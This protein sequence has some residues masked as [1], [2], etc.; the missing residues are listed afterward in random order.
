MAVVAGFVEKIKYRNEN[1]GWSILSV[2]AEGEEYVLVGT[3][4]VISEGEFI[5]AEGVMKVHPVY[6]EQLVV[7]SYEIKEPEDSE[8]VKR[9]LSSGAVKGIG[10]TLAARIVKRFKA[11]TLH[12]LEE[13][14][15]RLAE[16]KGISERM[17]M[18]IGA[19]VEEKREMR[20]A[21][22]FLSKFGI[23]MNLGVRI[24][25]QYGDRIYT[26]IREN[27][28]QLADEMTG[29]GFRI[30]DE[31]A[32][33]AGIL[34]DSEYRI[35]CG[36]LYCLS[37]AASQGHTYL[38][39]SLL[40][41]RTAELLGIEPEG[42]RQVL[43]DLQ[44][45]RKVV[46]KRSDSGIPAAGSAPEPQEQEDYA[47][48]PASFYYMELNV[49]AMLHDLD[50]RSDEAEERILTV[51]RGMEETDGIE[52][53]ELQRQAVIEAARSGLLIITGGPGTGKT[54]TI[55]AII[56]YFERQGAEILLAAPTG[57]AAKRM[58]ETTGC[59]AKTI[60]R[61][62]EITGAPSDEKESGSD[63]SGMHFERNE[64]MP[65]EADCVIIDEMSMVD[66]RLMH[67]LLKAVSVGTHLVL[68]GDSNQLPSVGPGNVLRDMISCNCFNV[69]RLDRIYRQAAES[70]IVVNAHRMIDG[71][72]IDL[73]K[74]SRDF[75]FIRQDQPEGI[76]NTM[77]TLIRDKLPS[78][79]GAPA[80]ELQ[81]MTPM[82]K[83]P[84]GVEQ[85]NVRL[86][87]VMN[88]PDRGKAEK[89]LNGILFRE[90]DKVMQIKNDYNRGVWNGDIGILQEINSFAET[91]TVLY[92]DLREVEYSYSDAEELELAY[93]I[94]IH[95]SQG[96]EYPA[97]VLPVWQ[98]PRMLL[99]R[100]LIYTAVTR[101]RKCVAMTGG[102]SFFYE[103]VNN[104]QELRRYTGLK[105][106]IRSMYGA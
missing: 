31:I 58:T 73:S 49:A 82:R 55:N 35:R 100:N 36:I 3:F 68:V 102:P 7:E 96:S 54:T 101:A 78:Y 24:W 43:S 20:K 11:E 9:W 79:V 16:V 56:R 57:R 53:D 30:A 90:G 74:R 29:I 19:Q 69:V 46:V 61:L 28:Y 27:P 41:R 40:L 88:P 52:F 65:L 71:E 38:P 63:W 2:S 75:L 99:T 21:M 93:A 97:V 8:G 51:I 64:Q 23:G 50:I 70:D 5:S 95:K 80:M 77:L 67:A 37:Q 106:R 91:L 103:M 26:L 83:G 42:M 81:I 48:Y 47:V 4:A 62:L 33:K 92:D 94:T 72:P 98:G 39:E 22:L 76:L 15:E 59:E 25:K 17:A 85:L 32:A 6:G 1:N 86:Q 84:L 14:P 12:V 45:D 13:E 10:D 105:D 18:E 34:R 60:H 89:E 44:M 104:T 87:E 66:I